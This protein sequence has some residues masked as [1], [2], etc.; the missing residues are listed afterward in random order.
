MPLNDY[1]ADSNNNSTPPSGATNLGCPG[2]GPKVNGQMGSTT[3]NTTIPGE[4]PNITVPRPVNYIPTPGYRAARQSLIKN[5]LNYKNENKMGTLVNKSIQAQR[6][7]SWR[8][9]PVLPPITLSGVV[10]GATTSMYFTDSANLFATFGGTTGG[11]AFGVPNGSATAANL[12]LFLQTM[13]IYVQAFNL[14]SSNVN[15]LSNNLQQIPV[16]PDGLNKPIVISSSANI[17][18]QQ[19]NP[20]LINNCYAFIMTFADALKL[21]TSGVNGESIT[22]TLIPGAVGFYGSDLQDFINQNPRFQ[23]GL[24]INCPAN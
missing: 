15:T 8:N 19:F 12:H 17:S 22:L 6:Y 1:N 23:A 4:T 5:Q 3:N 24:P 13:W 2:C 21:P 7:T 16:D 18:N 20:N 9:Y 14:D 10:A 11:Q